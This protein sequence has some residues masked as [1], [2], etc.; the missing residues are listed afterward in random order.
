[1][2]KTL[3]YLGNKEGHIYVPVAFMEKLNLNENTPTEMFIENGC[4]VIRPRKIRATITKKEK[5]EIYDA[6]L[7]DLKTKWGLPD[8]IDFRSDNVAN[9]FLE[10]FLKNLGIEVKE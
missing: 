4:I 8:V 7:K 2:E 6:S 1:M 3:Y 5:D 9:A 10:F